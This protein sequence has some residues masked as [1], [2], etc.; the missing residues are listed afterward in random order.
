MPLR[1]SQ[2]QG[3]YSLPTTNL[4]IGLY[5]WSLKLAFL[6]IPCHHQ[7]L[8]SVCFEGTEWTIITVGNLN[9]CHK[10][11]SLANPGYILIKTL[12]SQISHKIW[13]ICILGQIITF[14]FSPVDNFYLLV[15]KSSCIVL[16]NS[17]AWVVCSYLC[18][19]HPLD[20]G[21]CFFQN[22]SQHLS[23]Q[24]S[25]VV[26]I[27]CG[28]VSP[29]SHFY[30]HPNWDS[31]AGCIGGRSFPCWPSSSPPLARVKISFS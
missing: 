22:S 8:S 7:D 6:H 27:H 30:V 4:H 5:I 28:N 12:S 11:N 2:G 18:H 16:I 19:I 23:R 17:L 13:E 3:L 26:P 31:L 9:L 15:P 25:D 21:W 14:Q 29:V 20:T 10:C 24:A 1:L